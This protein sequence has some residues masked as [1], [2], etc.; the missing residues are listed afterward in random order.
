MYSSS[1]SLF[2]SVLI[3]WGDYRVK[4]T[5]DGTAQLHTVYVTVPNTDVKPDNYSDTVTIRV[6]Y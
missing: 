2:M 1:Y 6:N 4:G 3:Y 5:G